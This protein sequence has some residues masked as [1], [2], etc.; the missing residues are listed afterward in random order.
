MIGV[1]IPAGAMTGYL[2]LRHR[3]QTGSWSY[4]ASYPEGKAAWS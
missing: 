1:Q 4:P 3:F 2:F